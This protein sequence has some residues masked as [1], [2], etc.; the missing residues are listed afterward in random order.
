VI[1][2]K[3]VCVEF[4]KEDRWDIVSALHNHQRWREDR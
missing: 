1:G 3:I 4:A 2:N